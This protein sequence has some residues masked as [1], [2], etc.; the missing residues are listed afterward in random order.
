MRWE[1][2]FGVGP[3]KLPIWAALCTARADGSNPKY[4]PEAK[5]AVLVMVRSPESEVESAIRSVLQS[6]GW[7][8]PAIHNLKTLNDPFRSGDPIMRTCHD[9]AAKKEGGIIV[10]SDPMEE[11]IPWSNA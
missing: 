7:R 10:Y 2:F 3:K 11:G 6:N 8:E 4:L 5:H 1:R 9:A